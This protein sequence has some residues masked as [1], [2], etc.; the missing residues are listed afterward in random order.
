MVA[1]LSGSNYILNRQVKVK[2]SEVKFHIIIWS[3]CNFFRLDDLPE[4]TT[5]SKIKV[6]LNL[7]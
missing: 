3:L 6:L 1:L 4:Q 2:V 7:V 5:F